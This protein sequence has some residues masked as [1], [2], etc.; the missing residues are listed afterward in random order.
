MKTRSWSSLF[1]R[2]LQ[3]TSILILCVRFSRHG[4]FIVL[5][6]HGGMPIP[7]H[8]AIKEISSHSWWHPDGTGWLVQGGRVEQEW[9]FWTHDILLME[10]IL[11][12]L[13]C[14]KPCKYNGI[15]TISTGAG[16]LP[17]TVSLH[18]RYLSQQ[19]SSQCVQKVSGLWRWC[20]VP[21]LLAKARVQNW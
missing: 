21:V 19:G 10:E 17:P 1:G 8:V 9:K 20:W 14:I 5:R 3:H 15:F 7:L 12:H 13:G 6:L 2:V 11:H 16:F 18:L 4:L